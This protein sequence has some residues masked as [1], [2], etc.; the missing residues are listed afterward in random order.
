MTEDTPG[1]DDSSERDES[2]GGRVVTLLVLGLIVL[3]GG[4]YV[5]AHLVAGD[6]VPRGATV[7]GVAIGGHTTDEAARILEDGLADR[8]QDPFLV[9]M[10]DAEREVAPDEVG[11]SVDHEASVADA[12]GRKSWSPGRLWEYWTGGD[13][14]DPVVD[15]DDARFDALVASLDEEFGTPVTEGAV[16]FDGAKVVTVEPVAG[17]SVDP[18][19]A[20]NLFRTAFLGKSQ[21]VELTLDEQAPDID[22]ADVAQ[23]LETFANPAVADPV[24]LRFDGASVTLRPEEYTAALRLVA[25]DG[26]L[27]PQ[28][29][30]KRLKRVLDGALAGSG[31]PVEATVKLVDGKPTVVPD[32]PGASFDQAEI[33]AK[34]LDLVA[35]D[36]AD[37]VAEVEAV[38]TRAEFRT[39][40]AEA[41]NIK[42]VAGEFTTH[43]PHAAYRNTN[44][45][46]AA[47]IINGTV[48]KPGETFSMNDIV[49]ERTRA[50]GFTEGIMIAN[51]VFR[52]DLGGGVSQ[53]ATTL[54]NAM[55]FAGLEDV[56]HKPHS[57][58]IDR[59]P[60]GRE[61]T[62]AWGS[63]DLRFRNNTDHG[64][65]VQSFIN[66]S[67]PSSQG[68]VTVRMWSTK[69]WDIESVTGQ[70]YAFTSPKTRTLTSDNCM[71]NRG[72]G[73]F[74]IDVTRVFRKVGQSQVDRREK[75]HTVYTPSDTVVCRPAGS[76]QD[77]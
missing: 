6:K 26:E 56:E 28:L 15:V 59:Y 18:E 14:L 74:S 25:E 36:R 69:L 50:N 41:L 16:S 35:A 3:G 77:D 7:A 21:R 73:G 19:K 4:G 29:R 47:E 45:G 10:G 61:A 5:A 11:L 33:D 13:D 37:R 9:V 24:E 51:G 63:I 32:K 30:P 75:F 57:F 70:R 2:T 44:I 22:E 40:D 34:F 42:E 8:V 55:F 62:V 52:Q 54:F 53:M 38:V 12:G 64:V 72:Y 17:E 66:P 76:G 60:V 68:S 48:L 49:G 27:K 58:Y 23:A 20:E 65:L 1:P 46:R 71:P 31:G 43:Y 67:T 39:E